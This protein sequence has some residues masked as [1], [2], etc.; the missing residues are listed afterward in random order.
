MLS[1]TGLMGTIGVAV[2]CALS[3]WLIAVAGQMLR[4]A[5]RMAAHSG[6]QSV[7]RDSKA[8]LLTPV[9]RGLLEMKHHG[10]LL[11]DGASLAF[12][13]STLREGVEVCMP[14]ILRAEAALSRGRW[15]RRP[16]LSVTYLSSN[17]SQEVVR[18]L[19]AKAPEFSHV[20]TD[21]LSG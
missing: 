9:G 20:I 17:G 12:D 4:S 5:P 15:P 16:M 1:L 13:A 8:T 21:H 3:L 7:L 6:R 2:L 18:I 19:T 10:I 11:W 14:A